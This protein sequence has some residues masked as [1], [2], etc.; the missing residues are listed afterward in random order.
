MSIKNPVSYSD[1][2][3]KHS[4]DA[5][6]AYYEDAEKELAAKFRPILKEIIAVEELPEAYKD[7]LQEFIE[8]T[9]QTTGA[10]GMRFASEIADSIVSG[11]ISPVVRVANQAMEF[12][13]LSN[14]L[15]AGQA[16]TLKRRKK[17]GF[18]IYEKYM[19]YGGYPKEQYD[20]LYKTLEP[21]PSIPDL[22]MYGRYQKGFDN[23][24]GGVVD[25]YDLDTED[26]KIWKWLG[27][28][29]LTTLQVQA[30]LKRGELKD[31]EF[32]KLT[33][34]IGW[35]KT[36]RVYMENLAY[37]LPNSMLL[38]QGGLMQELSDDKIIENISKGD[39]HPDYAQTYLD[40]VLT[41][42][43]SQD[44][45][46]YGLRQ[47]ASL[48]GIESELSKIGIHPDYHKVYKE[49]AF[50]IPPVAD[51][52]TMA[53]R[54][55][56]TP[57]IAAKFGQ[58]EDLPDEFVEWAGKKGLTKDWASR[59]WAAHWSL[60]S[61]QQG[62]EMLHR[63][64]INEN[65]LYMLMRALDIMPFWRDKLMRM[66]YRRLTRVDVRRMYREGV[67]NESEVLEAY[68]QHGYAPEN[69]KR[70]TEFTIK[71]SLSQMSKFTT[72]DVISAFTKQ[73]ISRGEAS[74]L[75]NRLGVRSAD[76]DYI[77]STAV[78]KRIWALTEQK[79]KGIRNL[80]RQAVYNENQTRDSLS[81]LDLPADRI[82][83]LMTQWY[84]EIE[85]EDKRTWT[86]AQ[87]LGFMKD[88]LITSERGIKELR[89]IGYD[90]EHID[91]YIKGMQ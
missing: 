26:F 84:Y 12:N 82:A 85:A 16:T 78:Y 58:Y 45:L 55:A 27:Q 7:Y 5:Q 38:V 33:G 31:G 70:M 49:L 67:L 50:Q 75:L 28:Q 87:T 6:K 76:R 41:K 53:V 35:D 79:I 72:A 62:F 18:D 36:D 89:I 3:W 54:E 66:S 63:G 25:I 24:W 64:I 10:V 60:P 23:V 4:V 65:E 15:T 88:G 32:D 77:L 2:Y 37:T 40:A 86:T 57:S 59:Y 29:R 13:L 46:A 22:I 19:K 8:P 69:A 56:F 34:Y 9:S 71:Q 73:M 90:Q 80:Y 14:I 30:L 39:I 1:W 81:R 74:S 83:A 17:I 48:A 42:P 11:A 44:L 51:I 91:V 68:L 43:A 21:Y 20:K 52:I 61:P 47:D